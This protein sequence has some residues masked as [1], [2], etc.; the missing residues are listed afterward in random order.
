ML[1]VLVGHGFF[2]K[3]ILCL[4]RR[5]NKGDG[6]GF[7]KLVFL[8]GLGQ[9]NDSWN[10]VIR[11]LDTSNILR[12]SLHELTKGSNSF[13]FSE[14]SKNLTNLLKTIEEPFILIGLSL[15]GCFAL[16][17]GISNEM[18]HLKGL[19][20][21]GAQYSMTNSRG[22]RLL[23]FIQ[24]YVFNLLPQQVWQKQGLD[25]STVIPLYNSMGN[26]DL[27]NQL[28][29]ITIPTY[30]IVGSKDKPNITAAKDIAEKIPNAKLKMIED[31]KHEL[32]T[33]MPRKFANV[34]NEFMLNIDLCE[35]V[36]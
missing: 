10:G 8:H 1:V 14:L 17:Q 25:K 12:I 29:Q 31:G 16:Q 20:V 19:V 24:K 27:S 13:T 28:R 5:K 33:Q 2:N 18:I 6:I 3:P 23:F 35:I 21:S 30:V 11:Y 9:S 26:F 15:G 32:N 34:L 36:R 22:I 7:M 4:I